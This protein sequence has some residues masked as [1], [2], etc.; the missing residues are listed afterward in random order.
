MK[1]IFARLALAGALAAGA[2]GL[3][4]APVSAG[5]KMTKGGDGI[6][7]TRCYGRPYDG[8][9]FFDSRGRRI[10]AVFLYYSPANGGTFCAYTKNYTGSRVHMTVGIITYDEGYN[11]AEDVG[12]YKY[13]AGTVAVPRAKYR[14]IQVGGNYGSNHHWGRRVGNCSA[15]APPPRPV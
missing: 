1:R 10:G 13:Y 4:S 5:G 2:S 15:G 7:S 14:C 9:T 8:E 12:D 11:H 6:T 3:V